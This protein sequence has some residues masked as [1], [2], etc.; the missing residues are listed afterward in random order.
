MAITIRNRETEDMVRKIGERWGEGPSAVVK[1]LAKKELAETRSVPA[2]E[3]ARRMQVFDDLA[4]EFPPQDP[5][6]SWE[7]LEADMQAMFDYLDE[8]PGKG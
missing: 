6:P 8:E 5:K 3:Y 1:R 7:E 4:R 2:D